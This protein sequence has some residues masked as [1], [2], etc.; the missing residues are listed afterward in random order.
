[1]VD[2]QSSAIEVPEIV[3][4]YDGDCALCHR[5]VGWFLKRDR[6]EVIFFA[7][8]QGETYSKIDFEGP[9]DLST[10]VLVDSRRV[11]TR[12]NAVLAGLRAIGGGWGW[13]AKIARIIP[14]FVRDRMYDFVAGRRI[15]W[16]GP[17]DACTLPGDASRF[18]P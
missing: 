12:S 16:F 8:L 15:G 17:A 3:L 9:R 14:R 10:M 11:W 18:L 4:F 7:P 5:C 6:R 1:M 13:V 2:V